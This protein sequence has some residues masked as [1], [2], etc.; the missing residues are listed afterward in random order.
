MS[1]QGSILYFPDF[2]FLYRIYIKKYNNIYNYMN[3]INN[4]LGWMSPKNTGKDN[5]VRRYN[6]RLIC[7]K[8]LKSLSVKKAQ[9]LLQSITD[10]DNISAVS[11]TSHECVKIKLCSHKYSY[12]IQLI[13]FFVKTSTGGYRYLSSCTYTVSEL[14]GV[15]SLGTKVTRVENS[16]ST[17]NFTSR[18]SLILNIEG[19]SF[20]FPIFIEYGSDLKTLSDSVSAVYY[21]QR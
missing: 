19:D 7:F 9:A 5:I 21:P 18:F 17:Y 3:I 4:I 15:Q 1:S 6:G 11:D 14:C 10:K 16:S 8:G 12:C 13:H 2:L 20:E